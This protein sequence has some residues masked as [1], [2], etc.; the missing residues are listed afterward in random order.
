MFY[1]NNFQEVQLD[2]NN[3]IIDNYDNTYEFV[4]DNFQETECSTN[5]FNCGLEE[6]IFFTNN[7]KMVSIY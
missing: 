4:S 6:P 7:G 3:Q 5:V 2:N 1:T